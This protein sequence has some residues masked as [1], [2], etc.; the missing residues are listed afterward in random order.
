[1]L[2]LER[3]C[4]ATGTRGRSGSNRAPSSSPGI[5]TPWAYASNVTPDFSRPGK[6]KDNALIEAFNGRFRTECLNTHWFL[7]LADAREKLEAW[8]KYYNE[9]CPHGTIGNN[10]PISTQSFGDATSPSS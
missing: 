7:T 8:R 9:V 1:M 5:S 4:A 3:T 2:T 6:P 10:V